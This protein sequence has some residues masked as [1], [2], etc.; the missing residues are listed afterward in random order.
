MLRGRADVLVDFSI[1]NADP[2]RMSDEC[3]VDDG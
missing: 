3:K 1:R 2:V